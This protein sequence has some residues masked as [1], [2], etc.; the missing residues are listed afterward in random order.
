[1][2]IVNCTGCGSKELNEEDGLIV[3]AFCF[4][5][6]V[7]DPQDSPGHLTTIGVGSDI[8]RLLQMCRTDPANAARY[9]HLVLDMDPT[10]AEARAYLYPP[11][12]KKKKWYE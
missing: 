9:A 8:Q 6:Y 3:C 10:N 7:P 1:M 4:T 2:K 11:S 12:K 5:K